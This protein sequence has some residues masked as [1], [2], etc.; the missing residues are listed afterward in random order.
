VDVIV[1][2]L[3]KGSYVLGLL[4]IFSLMLTV[5]F[6]AAALGSALLKRARQGEGIAGSV[7][8]NVIASIVFGVLVAIAASGMS[9][10]AAT[11]TGDFIRELWN[12][13]SAEG[14]GQV[15][16]T[17]GIL[18]TSFLAGVGRWADVLPT[19]VDAVTTDLSD[20]GNFAVFFVPSL[21]CLLG[22]IVYDLKRSSPVLLAAVAHLAVFLNFAAL[23][24]FTTWLL[25]HTWLA[26]LVVAIIGGMFSSSPTRYV[27]VRA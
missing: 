23:A 21:L 15:G 13:F 12:G 27:L 10:S 14:L 9:E 6:G 25:M 4:L 2:V 3:V 16:S 20:R 11:A 22:L 1:W 8:I 18:F 7:V 17:I 26:L 24:A 19:F 5:G